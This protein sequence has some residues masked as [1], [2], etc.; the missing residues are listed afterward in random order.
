MVYSVGRQD[1]IVRAFEMIPKRKPS[2]LWV[3]R[4]GEFYYRNMDRWLEDNG[5]KRY[6]TYNESKVVGHGKI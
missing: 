2:R 6:S 5:I 4:G 3:D 1:S